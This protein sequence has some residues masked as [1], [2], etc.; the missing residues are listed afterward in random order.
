MYVSTI[1]DDLEMNHDAGLWTGQERPISSRRV[2]TYMTA[3]GHVISYDQVHVETSKCQA[4]QR[5]KVP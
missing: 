5:R 2:P 3:F 4:T 1:L